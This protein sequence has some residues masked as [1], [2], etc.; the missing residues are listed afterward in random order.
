MNKSV[1]EKLSYIPSTNSRCPDVPPPPQ[2]SVIGE[3]QS[4][5]AIHLSV[6][7]DMISSLEQVLL[8]PRPSAQCEAV[9]TPFGIQSQAEFLAQRTSA[10]AERLQSLRSSL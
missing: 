2:S 5:T 7:E 9:P 3:L 8:G 1:R 6:A 4:K 10:L